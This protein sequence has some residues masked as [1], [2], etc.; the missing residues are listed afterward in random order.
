MLFEDTYQTIEKYS[1]GTFRDRG[2]KFIGRAYPVTTE[3]EAKNILSEIRKKYHDANHHC[4]AYRIGFDKS[5]FRTNDDGEP[6]GTAGRPI[7]GQI[8]SKDLTNILII[9]TRYFGGT[10][11]G[12]SGLINAYKTSA[13]EALLNANIITKNVYDVYEITYDYAIMN[14]V[15]KMLKDKHADIISTNFEMTCNVVFKIRKSLSDMI[16]EYFKK[17]NSVTINYLRTE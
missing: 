14:E 3:D 7:F 6:S 2:S 17:L 4:Y 16:Y 8:Q 11:L 10:L 12:V 15:M 1:E 9:V 13:A 5:T